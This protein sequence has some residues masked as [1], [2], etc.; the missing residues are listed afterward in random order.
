MIK[1]AVLGATGYTGIELIRLIN[2]HPGVSLA[3]ATSESHDG[4]KISDVHPQFYGQP[5]LI[6][7]KM[8]PGQI[9]SSIDVVFCA[10]PHGISMGVVE[11]I[12][13]SASEKNKI[14]DLSADFR[15]NNIS[16]YNNWY[17]QEHTAP[18]LNTEAVYGLPE[19]YREQLRSTMLVA[20]PGCYPTVSILSLAPLLHNH[21]IK[22]TGLIIDAKSGVSGAGRTPGRATH[23]SE[24]YN[25]FKAYKVTVHRH[26]SEIREKL[27]QVA[28]LNVKLSFTPHLVPMQRGILITVYAE[29]RPGVLYGSPEEKREQVLDCYRNSY[30]EEPWIKIYPA[31]VFPQ[32]RDVHATNNCALAA[33]YD[34]ASDRI[35][36]IGAIDNLC[37]GASGQAVQNMNIVL[38][39]EEQMGLKGSFV[40]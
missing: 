7:E 15:Y 33:T 29:P 26:G 25:N 34:P 1:A 21:L 37:K 18:K 28:G 40:L 31:G 36:I 39:L 5:E 38:D 6:L 4:K 13:E 19:L 12:M 32:T 8:E 27:S 30:A 23:F 24:V 2:S 11:N 9:P 16:T 17:K 14:I 35:I 20:N 10:L 3:L 22:E